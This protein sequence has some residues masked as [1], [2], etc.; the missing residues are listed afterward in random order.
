MV[1]EAVHMLPGHMH[2]LVQLP[3]DRSLP[4]IVRWIK[5]TSTRLLKSNETANESFRWQKGFG[6]FSVSASQLSAVRKYIK[7]QSLLH[8]RRTFDEEYHIWI[9]RYD[10]IA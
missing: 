2:V 7:A 9:K 5:Q 1:T 6:A 4:E 10:L 8:L 3:V